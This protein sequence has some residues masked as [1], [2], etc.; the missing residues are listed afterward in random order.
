MTDRRKRGSSVFMAVWLTFWTAGMLVAA[1]LLGASVLRGD[2]AAAPFLLIW[3]AAA[4]LGLLAGLRKLQ[5]LLGL[6]R[7]APRRPAAKPRAWRDGMPERRD[8]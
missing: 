8:G 2:Y 6:A 7:P 3:L 1:W 5:T 4:A